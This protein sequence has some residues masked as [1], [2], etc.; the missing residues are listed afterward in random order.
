MSQR[1]LRAAAV[2]TLIALA[3]MVWS[4]L[5]PTPMPVLLAMS[6]G[7]VFGTA[8]FG[9]FGYVVLRDV[10]RQYIR[11]RDAEAAQERS[12]AVPVVAE[13]KAILDEPVTDNPDAPAPAPGKD[14][15]P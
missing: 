13:M 2:L 9:M 7:Q 6:L 3:L 14:A 15:P 11:R 1:F 8:A 12:G 4:V 10:R 5:Q